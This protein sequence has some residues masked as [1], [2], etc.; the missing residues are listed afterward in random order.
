MTIHFV[1]IELD[2]NCFQDYDFNQTSILVQELNAAP[3]VFIINF[4]RTWSLPRDIDCVVQSD[5][6]S[7]SIHRSNMERVF[8]SRSSNLVGQSIWRAKRQAF[9]LILKSTVVSDRTF[10]D[11]IKSFVICE[12][13]TT[14]LFSIITAFKYMNRQCFL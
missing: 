8:L 11:F 7:D 13:V 14:K 1:E 5:S 12:G 10:E 3:I 9:A 2:E 6:M 4:L